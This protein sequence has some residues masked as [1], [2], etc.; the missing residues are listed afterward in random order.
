MAQGQVTMDEV[1]D[2]V[3]QSMHQTVSNIQE[4][5][6]QTSQLRES[7][8]LELNSK[9]EKVAQREEVEFLLK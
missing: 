2:E 6:K 5:K 3:A 4:V 7:L 9:L 8:M 1:R